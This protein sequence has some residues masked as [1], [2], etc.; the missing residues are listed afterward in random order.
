MAAPNP[1]WDDLVTTT[2][3][4]RSPKIASAIAKK[5]PLLRTLEKK[6]NLMTVMGGRQLEKP[7]EY[8]EN[9]TFTF[10]RDRDVLNISGSPFLT[11]AVYEA[12][13]AAIFIEWSRRE[14]LQNRGKEQAINWIAAKQRNAER[15]AMN[16]IDLSLHSD[17]T[18]YAGNEI[19]GLELLVADDPTSGTVGGIDRASNAIWR[20]YQFSVA[21]V[22]STTIV[23]NL[24]T[25]YYNMTQD[26][27]DKPDLILA[28]VNVYRAYE[29]AL[30][31]FQRFTTADVGEAGFE[32]LMFKTVPMIL[33]PNAGANR[34]YFLNTDF[35]FYEV[36]EGANWKPMEAIRS[37]NQFAWA[38]G[39]HW[40]GNLTMSNAIR[41]GVL[42][43]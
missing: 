40:M 6:G 22:T 41:Q 7:L 23:S 20:N 1:S 31:Q 3:V 39:S 29:N 17:G 33:D 10:F 18:G 35:L 11:G 42:H 36:Y 25:L 19:G 5:N 34:A 32:K 26:S 14:E 28:G 38:K 15:T 4:N 27:P 2:L 30:Q 12:K 24:N 9:S 21:A 43:T 8:A 13:E 37:I 16:R